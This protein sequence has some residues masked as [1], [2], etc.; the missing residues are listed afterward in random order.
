VVI[1][2][3]DVAQETRQ[4]SS[5]ELQLHRELK[6]N[7]LGL[8]SLSR[9]IAGQKSRNRYW[10]DGG[11]N[12]KFF[13]LQAC[14]RKSK[15][16]IPTFVHEGRT[17]TSDEAKSSEA[18]Y[19]YYSGL[20]GTRFQRLHRIDLHRLNLPRIDLQELAAPFTEEEITRIVHACPPDRA[21]GPD[22]YVGRFYRSA[23]PV[24]KE[25]ICNTFYAFVAA[26]LEK[27]VFLRKTLWLASGIT[28]Q[29]ALFTALANS[30]PKGS[31]C[32]WHPS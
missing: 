4:L 19:D 2:E 11:A 6:A 30:Y 26:R 18:V 29:L 5:E 10:K 32:G 8:A 3:L 9:S 20:L 23:W 25:D 1:Y 27:M 15:S 21:P 12:T 7:A 22:G 13:H 14:H 28:G 16:Y 17:F 24:I 31:R